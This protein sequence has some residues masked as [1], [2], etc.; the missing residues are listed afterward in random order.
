MLSLTSFLNERETG[1]EN[2]QFNLRILGIPERE[3][4]ALTA[5]IIEFTELGSFIHAPVQTYSSGMNAR[6]AFGITTA[7]TPEILIVD[8]VLGVGDGYFVGKATERMIQLCEKGKALL[9][10]SHSLSTLQMLCNSAIWLDKGEIRMRGSVSDVVRAY[11][12]DFRRRED[13]AIRAQNRL[14]SIALDGAALPEDFAD[15]S[16]WRLRIVSKENRL[17][18]DI[19][20]INSIELRAEGNVLPI[21]MSGEADGSAGGFLDIMDSE[22][23]RP[24]ERNGVECRILSTNTGKRRGGHILLPKPKAYT[25]AEYPIEIAFNHSVANNSEMLAVEYL[26]E[27]SGEW[28]RLDHTV[29]EEEEQ[30]KVKSWRVSAFSGILP[31]VAADVIRETSEQSRSSACGRRH[32]K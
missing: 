12:E 30:P 7:I 1:L 10:V 29:T 14:R 23:G 16:V 2:I 3:I 21:L 15:P 6:L 27:L 18:H 17:F 4:P 24:Y 9:Y 31:L 32:Y 11:E 8:E 20:Y 26:N 25:R 5:E 22:W 28:Q 13:K 19:H